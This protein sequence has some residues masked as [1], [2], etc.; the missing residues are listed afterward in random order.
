MCLELCERALAI[1]GNDA[2]VLAIVGLE[3]HALKDDGDGGIALVERALALN[4]HSFF[5]LNLAATVHLQRGHF[6]RAI[7][8]Y[9]R[10]LD[11]GPNS[12]SSYWSLTGIADAHLNAGRFEEA[13]AWATRSLNTQVPW[14]M[15]YITLIVAYAM[16]DRLN[17]ARAVLDR[18]QRH[19]PGVT[20]ADLIER[21]SPA[22]RA[23]E[24]YWA[25]GLRKAGLPEA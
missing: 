25:E 16:L 3:F 7:D 15:T 23:I 12:P 8:L 2:I 22:L 6:D 1:A 21:L 11:L 20:I 10:T 19:R 13:I 18:L 4:P 17:E 9:R 14:D 5:V 24:R